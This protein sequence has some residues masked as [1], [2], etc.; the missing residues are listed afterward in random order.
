MDIL[1]AL[2][3]SPEIRRYVHKHT[4]VRR[5]ICV[6][7]RYDIQ[8]HTQATLVDAEVQTVANNQTIEDDAIL[9]RVEVQDLRNGEALWLAQK[10]QLQQT[11]ADWQAKYEQL[12]AQ[13]E[14]PLPQNNPLS[15]PDEPPQ[16]HSETIDFVNDLVCIFRLHSQY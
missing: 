16:G 12:C 1:K 4:P 15:K 9:L 2:K 14:P 5:S 13:Q 11:I 6:S 8:H 3:Y 10:K 7:S